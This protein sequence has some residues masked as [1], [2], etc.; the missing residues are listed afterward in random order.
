M[1]WRVAFSVQLGYQPPARVIY[2]VY[3][4]CTNIAN[5][6]L[7]GL[8]LVVGNDCTVVSVVHTYRTPYECM[9]CPESSNNIKERR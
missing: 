6:L 1:F 3:G 5:C 4:R 9:T 2:A 8:L 7:A